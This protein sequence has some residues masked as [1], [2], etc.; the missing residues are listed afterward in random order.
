MFYINVFWVYVIFNIHSP[1]KAK[2][3]I[4]LGG[5]FYYSRFVI[6]ISENWD[7]KKIISFTF[8]GECMSG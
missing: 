6:T 8:F 1:K 2:D 4:F 5:I 7:I 3:I